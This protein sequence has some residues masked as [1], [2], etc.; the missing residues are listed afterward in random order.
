MNWSLPEAC[1]CCC[2]LASRWNG[3]VPLVNRTNC[4]GT[5]LFLFLIFQ[6]IFLKFLKIV[7]KMVLSQKYEI[8]YSNKFIN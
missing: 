4:F 5:G 2:C 3:L 1:S 6:L 8:S 7:V